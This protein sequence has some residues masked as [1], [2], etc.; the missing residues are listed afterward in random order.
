MKAALV[1]VDVQH[2]YLARPGLA[3]RA[4]SLLERLTQ[5]ISGCRARG[6][7]VLHVHTRIDRDGANRMA[8]LRRGDI[9]W[10]VEGTPGA[11]PPP[12]AAPRPGEAVFHKHVFNAFSDPA[13]SKHLASTGVDALI[14]AGVHLHACVRETALAA[15]QA[16]Y[17]VWIADDAVASYDVLHAEVSRNYLDSRGMKFLPGTEVL[18][19]IDAEQGIAAPVPS[20]PGPMAAWV[21]G[22][23]LPGS[24]GMVW[25]R[26][27]PARW[28]DLLGVVAEASAAQIEHAV[29]L[30]AR[31]Q[32]HWALRRAEERGRCLLA[33]AR[34]LESRREPLA[35]A[36]T[37]EVGKPV[38]DALGEVERAI[39]LTRSAVARFC[40]E[41]HWER[42][43]G[44]VHARRVPVGVVAAVT[45]FNHPLA[46][47]IGKLVPALALGNAAVWK[48]ALSAA[49]TTGL[50]VE[51][52]AE[53][54]M[55]EG[56]VAVVF[57]DGY[58]AQRLA[59]HAHVAMVT[60][61]ASITAGRQLASICGADLK[62]LQ[63]ELGG[64]NAVVVMGRTDI[65]RIAD[66]IARSAFSFAGQRCTAGRRILVEQGRYEALLE[67]LVG[68][69]MA[70]RVGEP[71]DPAT[72]IGPVVSRGQQQSVATA[73]EQAARSGARV[74]C[75]GTVPAGLGHG[76]WYAPTLV[77]NVA[78]DDAL[79]CE[80]T[81]GPVAVVRPIANIGEAIALVNGV[82]QG[83]VATLYSDD[84][85]EQ[86]RFLSDVQAGV[87]K[88]NRAPAGVHAEAPFGGW[89]ASGIGPPEHGR[90][91]EESYTRVQT[92]YG[93][94]RHAPG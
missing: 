89:K 85:T 28:D 83:L 78:P 90:W 92:L 8:H 55:P 70:L 49:A 72:D 1:L 63:G 91:D 22:Q 31:A 56:L 77:T 16:G 65:P 23:W 27:N 52:F 25:E 14:I 7:P 67:A 38:R 46:S 84:L 79:F 61:T 94:E 53:A 36:M 82:A 35:R 51:A 21:A 9:W 87:V 60:A 88:L 26:R 41:R 71:D 24:G 2:D 17:R 12:E 76:C 81:F 10:C 73:V 44:D 42:C 32:R 64:N 15:Y 50:V 59:R 5:L 37:S 39:E 66:D 54:G 48:P 20:A 45:P 11:E 13:L 68:A 18:A 57:G 47:A 30:A 40:G 62:P 4:E 19:R 3:P 58:T 33:F 29:T 80:E 86:Q 93:W 43:N 74:L 75:G 69:T 6:V 34:A